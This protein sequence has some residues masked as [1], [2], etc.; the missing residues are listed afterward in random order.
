[1]FLAES[2]L[3]RFKSKTS[4][5]RLQYKARPFHRFLAADLSPAA[6][7][8]S[9]VSGRFSRDPM[10]ACGSMPCRVGPV[11]HSDA[12]FSLGPPTRV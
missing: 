9:F 11:A 5:G 1:M 6:E 2:A 7:Q 4:R 3:E 12:P 10:S 8:T